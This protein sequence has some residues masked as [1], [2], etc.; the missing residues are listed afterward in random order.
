MQSMALGV[1]GD[2]A[3]AQPE[4]QGS[5][6]EGNL[7]AAYIMHRRKAGM[8]RDDPT[9]LET[10]QHVQIQ[11]WEWIDIH[12]DEFLDTSTVVPSF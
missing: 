9:E 12:R 1:C 7:E 11:D 10:K 3:T 5:P 6:V 4:A 2:V 8:V